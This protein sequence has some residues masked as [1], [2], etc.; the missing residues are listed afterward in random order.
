[1]LDKVLNTPPTIPL[2]SSSQPK[3]T[4]KVLSIW[5]WK[6]GRWE[7]YSFKNYFTLI[8]VG[9]LGVHFGVGEGRPCLKLVRIMLET[10][11]LVGKYTHIFSFRKYTFWYQDLLSFVDVSISLQKIAF[12]VK[13]STFPQ[14]DG[15]KT[16]LEIFEF[17]LQF[18]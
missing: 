3:Q 9:F 16:V 6:N 1:M 17:C 11:N 4:V 10:W 5:F 12:F 15:M 8:R 13:N 7:R 2:E 18:L 14:S